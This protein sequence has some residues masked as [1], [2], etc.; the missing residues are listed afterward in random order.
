MG[1]MKETVVEMGLILQ[2]LQVVF[3]HH[4]PKSIVGMEALVLVWC[5][6]L[7][8]FPIPLLK[9]A[10]RYLRSHEDFPTIAAM[11]RSIRMVAGV[12]SK[13]DCR[14]ELDELLT[15]VRNQ[16]FKGKQYHQ[17]TRM[18]YEA[19]GGYVDMRQMNTTTYDIA[20][21]R[22]YE[23]AAQEWFDMASKPE[24][25]KLLLSACKTPY[26]AVHSGS[27]DDK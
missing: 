9:D 21:N 26:L 10:A 20:L 7:G 17:I 3:P 27:S 6:D 13:R 4:F 24:N 19:L 23:L 16:R 15:D 25:I 1:S 12:P 5:S 22:E 18:V 11:H 2:A 8:H 14:I